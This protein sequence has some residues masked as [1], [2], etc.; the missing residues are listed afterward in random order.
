MGH[1]QQTQDAYWVDGYRSHGCPLW[2]TKISTDNQLWSDSQK[3]K[4]FVASNC[5]S[6]TVQINLVSKNYSAHNSRVLIPFIL[7]HKWSSFVL[8]DC[9]A[10]FD[11]DNNRHYSYIVFVVEMIRNVFSLVHDHVRI[12]IL[13]QIIHLIKFTWKRGKKQSLQC[14]II[15]EGSFFPPP[16]NYKTARQMRNFVLRKEF[17]LKHHVWFF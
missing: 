3:R 10:F 11:L 4:L 13:Q 5:F 1:V 14:Y 16:P 7:T 12:C 6:N 17:C 2:I 15:S 8:Y 9:P